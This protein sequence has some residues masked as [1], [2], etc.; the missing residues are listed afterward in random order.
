MKRIFVMLLIACFTVG[1]ADAQFG[2]LKGLGKKIE[3]AA[4]EK[5]EKEADK[6]KEDAKKEAKKEAKKQADKVKYNLDDDEYIVDNYN[7]YDDKSIGIKGDNLGIYEKARKTDWEDLQQYAFDPENWHYN[8]AWIANNALYYVN[9]WNK[10]IDAGDTEKMTANDIYTRVNWCISQILNMYSAEKLQGISKKEAKQL[11]DDYNK[12]V[13]KFKAIIWGGMPTPENDILPKERKT[14]ADYDLYAKNSLLKWGW[15]VDQ[16]TKAREAKKPNTHEFYV[17]QTIGFREV[18]FCWNY[19]QG[20]E[21]GF[22]EFDKKLSKEYSYTSKEYRSKNKIMSAQE[23]RD[24]QKSREEQWAKEKAEK[25]AKEEAEIEANTQDWP[26]SNMPSMDATV[27]KVMKAKFP[28]RKIYRV[29]AVGDRWYVRMKGLI[30]ESRGLAVWVEFE[31]E[32]GRRIAEQHQV[33]QYYENGRY[34]ATKYE[35]MNAPYFWVRQK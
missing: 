4:K 26:K 22:K 18:S 19:L 9:R 31:H 23:C 32:S 14:Q 24:L 30:P 6:A 3:K 34:G 5:V 15:C 2:K 8:T 28:K 25:K 29:A 33:V 11:V 35:C 12:G 10:A 13:E 20:T 27:L 21:D 1:V 17:H 16:A 7:S